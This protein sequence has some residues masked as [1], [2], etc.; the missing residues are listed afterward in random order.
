MTT[1]EIA[2]KA[3][4]SFL[5]IGLVSV[6][7]YITS[8]VLEDVKLISK[9]FASR[10]ELNKNH[11]DIMDKIE[12]IRETQSADYRIILGEINTNNSALLEKI[13]KIQVQ[14]AAEH[15][16]TRRSPED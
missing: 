9:T 4:L 10:E 14:L 8:N 13:S 16:N 11:K 7:G 1:G 3:G 6:G 15:G 2:V 12:D 5:G